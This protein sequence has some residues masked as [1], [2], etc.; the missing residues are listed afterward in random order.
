MKADWEW[1]WFPKLLGIVRV[2]L[3]CNVG[4]SIWLS[5]VYKTGIHCASARMNGTIVIIHIVESIK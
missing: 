5:Y 1:D 4:N 3:V 2:E